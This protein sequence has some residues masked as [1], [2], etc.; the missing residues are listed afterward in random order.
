M[1]GFL[2]KFD[3]ESWIAYPDEK[4]VSVPANASFAGVK[5]SV[6]NPNAVPV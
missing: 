3:F 1:V 2:L 6:K 5:R 4:E